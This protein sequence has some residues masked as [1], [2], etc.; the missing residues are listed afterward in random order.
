MI[1]IGI[2]P[3]AKGAL[4]VLTDRSAITYKFS[5]KTEYDIC[6]VL[7]SIA[8][9]CHFAMI[10]KVHSMPKQGVASTFK[11]GQNYGTLRGFLIAAALIYDLRWDDVTPMKWQTAM[12]CIT[13]PAYTG[14]QKKNHHKSKAQQLFPQIKITHAIADALLIAEYCRRTNGR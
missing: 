2:D 13:P 14:T 10:E 3:G 9:D 4:V 11:F 12:G 6:E 8:S 1:Y 5:D 7:F